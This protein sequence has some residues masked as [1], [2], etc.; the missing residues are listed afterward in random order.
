MPGLPIS[1]I[2]QTIAHGS[3]AREAIFMI[4]NHKIFLYCLDQAVPLRILTHGMSRF[5]SRAA[6]V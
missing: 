4:A 6:P 1:C 5:P 3:H 2:K